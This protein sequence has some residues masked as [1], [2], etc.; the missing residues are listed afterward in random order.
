M[1][2]SAA[3]I[4]EGQSPK[5]DAMCKSEESEEQRHETLEWHSEATIIWA[6]ATMTSVDDRAHSHGLG[7]PC[8]ACAAAAWPWDYSVPF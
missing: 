1:W 4:A 5:M 6:N 8:C 7:R 2:I 3:V